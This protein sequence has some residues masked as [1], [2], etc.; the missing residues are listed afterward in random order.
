[1][2]LVSR[3]IQEGF[4][5]FNNGI[6]FHKNPYPIFAEEECFKMGYHGPH[7]V[8]LKRVNIDFFGVW[9]TGWRIGDLIKKNSTCSVPSSNK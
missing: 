7:E 9:E 2:I 4:D 3:V 1:M 6:P 8:G 5:A